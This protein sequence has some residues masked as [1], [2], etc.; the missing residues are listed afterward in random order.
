MTHID[1][2]SVEGF[3]GIDAVEIDTGSF[4][5]VTGR[6]NSGKTSL[7][8][9]IDVA[10]QPSDI[11]QFGSNL[12]S[13]INHHH[14]ETEIE[15]I[16]ADKGRMVQFAPPQEELIPDYLHGAF[17]KHLY[18]TWQGLGDRELSEQDVKGI[19]D[20]ELSDLIADQVS[21]DNLT[22]IKD[23]MLVVTIN[24]DEYPYV[25]FG[26][27]VSDLYIELHEDLR[28]I[29]DERMGNKTVSDNNGSL[30]NLRSL[31]HFVRSGDYA[32]DEPSPLDDIN[33]I[34][35][36][37]LSRTLDLSE[38]DA[39]PVKIDNVGDF[40]KEKGL[41][42]D[43]K[44]FN[45]DHLIFES[46]E[47]EKYSVPFDHMG[48]GF[49]T[50]VGVLWELLDDDRPEDIVLLEE[51]ET[52]MH[53]GYVREL[54]Y[55]LIEVCRTDDVQLFVTTHNNDFLNDLFTENLTEDERKF[56][57]SEFRLV[58][59]QDGGADTMTYSEAE[60]QLKDLKLDLRGL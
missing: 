26:S 36:M 56:L 18:S 11:A 49:K 44:T 60:A 37:Q 22:D 53:P 54:I 3:K 32:G 25:H 47:G 38:E 42:E 39:D 50:T 19:I 55:F 21:Q 29:V 45:L 31:P 6:N 51:P 40:I 7:L 46:D 59:L 52:H 8:Q 57:E 28:E 14:S 17:K 24:G 13:L 23:E 10:F 5:V 41:V 2:L 20:T 1:H 48:E 58:Q 15:L 12:D 43:L 30:P 33:F 9:A 35:F 34:D 4:N 16:S 27:T